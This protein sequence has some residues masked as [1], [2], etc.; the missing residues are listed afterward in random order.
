M[1]EYRASLRDEIY[2]DSLGFVIWRKDTNGD[3]FILKAEWVDC[4][5]GQIATPTIDGPISETKAAIQAIVDAAYQHG[6]KPAAMALELHESKHMAAHL[7]DMRK[8]TFHALKVR[9]A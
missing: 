3:Q 8:L 9:A 1:S 7:E 4:R 6:I 2:A 5:P